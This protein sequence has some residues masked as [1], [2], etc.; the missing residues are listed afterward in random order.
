VGGISRPSVLAVS[1]VDHQFEVD[2]R[3][4]WQ[5]GWLPAPK[6]ANDVAG[7]APVLVDRVGAWQDGY[8]V[9]VFSLRT[10]SQP[11]DSVGRVEPHVAHL[12]EPFE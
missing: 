4:H 5:V 10:L 11:S 7:R 12:F 1:K 9:L 8:A 3:L 6:D 2:R